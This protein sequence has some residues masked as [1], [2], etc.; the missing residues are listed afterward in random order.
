M[1]KVIAL[2][3]AAIIVL[4]VGY[5]VVKGVINMFN[6]YDFVEAFGSASRDITTLWGLIKQKTE[7]TIQEFPMSN[8]NI[9]WNTARSW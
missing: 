4:T 8:K 1:V 9:T 7:T 5:V 3:L 2:I 6:G